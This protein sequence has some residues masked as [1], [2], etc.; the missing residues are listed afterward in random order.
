MF[1][2]LQLIFSSNKNEDRFDYRG[3]IFTQKSKIEETQTREQN[4]A[5]CCAKGYST[6]NLKKNKGIV[7]FILDVYKGN[8]VDLF[9]A[10]GIITGS[11][12][13]HPNDNE[14]YTRLYSSN[15]VLSSTNLE[16][17]DKIAEKL[18]NNMFI[19]NCNELFTSENPF[20]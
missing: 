18:K 16:D 9:Y 12:R 1:C 2:K 6:H 11:Y 13:R 10:S 8:F 3:T 17:K 5:Y 14:S 15:I 7:F 19:E 20:S 4:I